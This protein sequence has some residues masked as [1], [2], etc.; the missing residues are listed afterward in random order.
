MTTMKIYKSPYPPL[1]LPDDS[2]FTYILRARFGEHSPN[3][4]AFIDASSGKVITRG[5]LRDLAL[6]M[7]WGL[8]NHFARAGGVS[9]A[10]G[11]VVMIF[12]P[13]SIAWPV[14]LYGGYA[15]GLR[16]T[17]ANS[18]YTPREI[19]H[20]WTDSRA[21]A[22]LVHPAL[23]PVVLEMFKLLDLSLSD[24]KRRMIVIDWGMSPQPNIN[25]Y[26]T[27]S[28]I[29]GKGSL[30]E[31]EMFQ[32][33]QAHETTLLCYSSG[34]TGKP[35]GV[36][37]CRGYIMVQQTVSDAISCRLRTRT[38]SQSLQWSAQSSQ[39][40]G[41]LIPLC[42]AYCPSITFT[43]RHPRPFCERNSTKDET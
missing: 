10:R 23:L 43:V 41:K 13:N 7:G 2:V 29:L 21:K 33:G 18:A 19:L 39:T 12:S 38:L 11:D 20:Q 17:L 8:R 35:K 16:M 24:A 3:H 37:V 31:E 22:I 14:M 4:P 9:L 36:E 34:T 27:M 28:D 40:W 25:D 15:A 6:S 32:G 26:I 42:L 1:P 30:K 5:E